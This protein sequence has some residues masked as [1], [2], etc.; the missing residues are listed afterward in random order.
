[1]KKTLKKL[2]IEG[3]YF[4]IIWVY[5]LDQQPISLNRENFKSSSLRSRTRRNCPL[6]PLNIVLG[7]LARTIEKLKEIKNNNIGEK[8][9][10]IIML[11]NDTILFMENPKH[12]TK[13]IRTDKAI[14]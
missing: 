6:S 10:K 3:K 14:Q 5:I 12:S 8:A 13:K 11:A 1:M 7:L 2:G 4:K 9:I